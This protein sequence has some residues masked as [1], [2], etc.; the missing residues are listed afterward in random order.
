[1]ENRTE[2]HIRMVGIHESWYVPRNDS[3]KPAALM[4]V[5]RER[6]IIWTKV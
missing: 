6:N 1:M 3:Q 5:R 2:V 4:T